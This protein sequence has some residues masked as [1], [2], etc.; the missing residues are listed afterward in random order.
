MPRD[1]DFCA[2][3]SGRLPALRRT[4]FLLCGDWNQVD[5]VVQTTLLRLYVSWDRVARREA[6]DAYA[7]T[8]VVRAVLEPRRRLS[9]RKE[10][11]THPLP[12]VA[13]PESSSTEDRLVLLEGLRRISPGQRAV[14]VLRFWEDL[15]VEQ[16]AAVM[17]CST[18]TVK[19]QTA[20]GLAALRVLVGEH[21]VPKGQHP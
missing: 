15:D 2:Y 9:W 19:S 16:T 21:F 11:S 10:R 17:G 6:M 18:G 14:L 13:A 5:D 7:R 20:K 12:D 1:E 4:A 3:A 8:T